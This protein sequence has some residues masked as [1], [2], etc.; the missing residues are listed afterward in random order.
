MVIRNRGK[1]NNE[2]QNHYFNVRKHANRFIFELK[3]N[4]F[5]L[6]TDLSINNLEKQ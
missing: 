3:K 1:C 5:K 4:E 6:K 2:N